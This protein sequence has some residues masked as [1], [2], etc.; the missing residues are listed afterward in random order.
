[1]PRAASDIA[2]AFQPGATEPVDDGSVRAE[3][4]D[5]ERTDR[6]GF[7]TIPDDS[8]M[9]MTA[10]GSRAHGST[11][12][13]GADCKALRAQ[14]ATKATHEGGLAAKQMRTTGDIQEQA[15]WSIKRHQGRKPVTPLGKRI[16]RLGV[17][18]LIGIVHLQLRTDSAGIGERQTDFKAE[19]G[20]GF[21]EC[22]NLQC[23]VLFD[24]DNARTI[25][26]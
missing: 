11:G 19:S 20:C 9:D 25:M 16:Q 6:I 4:R 21:V 13:R 2:D 5:R 7:L 15:M 8:A 26:V 24:D 12:D 10:H 1:M 14:H 3:C 22:K 17:G 23:V 18:S